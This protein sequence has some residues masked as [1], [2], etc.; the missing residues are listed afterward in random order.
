[1]SLMLTGAGI[2]LICLGLGY[3]MGVLHTLNKPRPITTTEP[4]PICGCKHHFSMHTK[5]GKCMDKVIRGSYWEP[6]PCVKYIGPVPVTE[7]W[8]PPVISE[9]E[10]GK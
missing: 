7:I 6:C 8:V 1:M 3:W 10:Q 5:Q 9:L 4:K 2:A